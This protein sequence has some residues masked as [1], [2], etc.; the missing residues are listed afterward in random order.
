MPGP[1]NGLMKDCYDPLKHWTSIHRIHSG[2][3]AYRL[4][5][6]LTASFTIPHVSGSQAASVL[7]QYLYL[8]QRYS[9]AREWLE[10]PPTYHIEVKT[11]KDGLKGE[12][13]LTNEEWERARRLRVQNE[14]PKNVVL[15]IRVWDCQSTNP[16]VEILPDVWSWV[17]TG[18]VEMRAVHEFRGKVK[19][20][21]DA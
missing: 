2:Y 13:S 5:N 3:A 11:T 7:T 4:P 18:G 1:Q 6:A 9:P 21:S 10:D 15:L 20:V 19:A 14:R 8:V 17:E 16:R 12:F